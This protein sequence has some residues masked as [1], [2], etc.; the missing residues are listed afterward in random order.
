MVHAVMQGSFFAGLTGQAV[1]RLRCGG[2]GSRVWIVGVHGIETVLHRRP[3]QEYPDRLRLD[4]H[5]IIRVDDGCRQY[6]LAPIH[7]GKYLAGIYS[8]AAVLLTV[9]VI[10]QSMTVCADKAGV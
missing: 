4:N 10:D 1:W 5:R 8:A 2:V 3:V 6:V 9:K 7:I